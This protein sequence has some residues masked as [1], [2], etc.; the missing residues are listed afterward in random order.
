M[1]KTF[2][3]TLEREFRL[4]TC[5]YAHRAEFTVTPGSRRVS[6][7]N[8]GPTLVMDLAE[9][10]RHWAFL[11]SVKPGRVGGGFASAWKEVS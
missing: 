10:R 8:A 5:T 4:T 9:A 6:V 7:R 3:F 2:T 11:L 1:S